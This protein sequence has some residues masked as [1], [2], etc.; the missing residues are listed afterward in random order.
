MVAQ[1][2]AS[3]CSHNSSYFFIHRASASM[4]RTVKEWHG[5]TDDSPIPPRVRLRVFLRNGGTCC[6]GCTRKISPGDGWETDHIIAIVNGGKNCESNLQTLLRECHKHKTKIDVD[7]KSRTYQ[8]RKTHYGLRKR[9]RFK[10]W[11]RFDGSIVTNKEKQH[12]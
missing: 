1:M 4:A 2:A 10:A 3:S 6:C 11:R 8:K 12:G 7:T 9:T 5:R